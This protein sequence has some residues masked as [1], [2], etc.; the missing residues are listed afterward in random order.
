MPHKKT[1]IGIRQDACPYCNGKDIVKKGMREKK[2]EIVQL[3]YCNDCRKV[4]TPQL[5]KGKT[6]PLAVTF[7]GLSYHNL[8]YSLENSCKFLKAKYGLAVAPTTLNGWL[9][10]YKDICRYA[11]MR[12]Y[13]IK[14]YSPQQVMVSATLY[15]RQIYT[16]RYHRAKIELLLE[17]DFKN[18]PLYRLKEFLD[19]VSVECPHQLFREGERA[20]EVKAAW[21]MDHVLIREKQNFAN[22]LAGLALQAARNNKERHEVLERF[23]LANDS[24]TVAIEVPIYFTPED[25]GHMQKELEF[26]IPLTLEKVVT[27]HIDIVQLRNG[28]VHIL[29]YKPGARREK[30]IGQLMIY[31]LALSR[32][33]GL[34]LYHFKCGWFDEKSYHEF[35][36]LHVVHKKKKRSRMNAKKPPVTAVS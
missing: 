17:E 19:A 34:K 32:L 11:R 20:S 29:D 23:M 5:V 6:F 31:A 35:F 26:N 8:G 27:G 9:E 18:E 13:A 3:W 12:P 2:L 10:E 24:V 25:L 33:T 36:P 7:D 28:M 1:I 4:F 21:D 14:R 15:H 30:P 22:R 16:F